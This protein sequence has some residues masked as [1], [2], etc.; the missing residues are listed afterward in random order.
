MKK[1]I[2]LLVTLCVIVF[3]FYGEAK[4]LN[5][6][7]ELVP[8]NPYK[9]IYNKV[10]YYKDSL[11]LAPSPSGSIALYGIIKEG[12]PY[13]VQHIKL[14]MVVDRVYRSAVLSTKFDFSYSWESNTD[15]I[16]W[17]QHKELDSIDMDNIAEATIYSALMKKAMPYVHEVS[18]KAKTGLIPPNEIDSYILILGQPLDLD[19]IGFYMEKDTPVFN[20]EGR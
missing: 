13:N 15:S 19:K 6:L 18:H 2:L 16:K 11:I 7:Q 4:H 17:T 9:K 20:Y 3:P 5:N 12:D 1:I 14:I 8:L 10:Y